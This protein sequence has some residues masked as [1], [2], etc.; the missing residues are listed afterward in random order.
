MFA[1]IRPKVAVVALIGGMFAA[2]VS[3]TASSSIG[4][5]FSTADIPGWPQP[6]AEP[7][8]PF[9]EG[10]PLHCS[11]IETMTPANARAALER[12]GYRTIAFVQSTHGRSYRVD[13]LPR[14]GVLI[15]VAAQGQVYDSIASPDGSNVAVVFAAPPGSPAADAGWAMPM[16]EQRCA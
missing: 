6:N 2:V 15:A 14:D 4:A 12:L 8:S 13:R 1:L 10:E 3:L 9:A 7:P 5:S 11:G 16:P